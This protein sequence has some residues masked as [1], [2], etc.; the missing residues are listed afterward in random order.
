MLTLR[1]W[2]IK[3]STLFSR[4]LPSITKQIQLCSVNK[5]NRSKYAA[6]NRLITYNNQAELLSS[7]SIS[8]MDQSR[9]AAYPTH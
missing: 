3:E 9:N 6:C 2:T 5:C 1:L 4:S 7:R 8:S